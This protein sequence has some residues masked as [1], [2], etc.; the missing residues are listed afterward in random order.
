MWDE[1]RRIAV[2]KRILPDRI[3]GLPVCALP[4][5]FTIDFTKD[6]RFHHAARRAP[7]IDV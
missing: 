2:S 3:S 4:F 6:A 7:S 5:D 1:K